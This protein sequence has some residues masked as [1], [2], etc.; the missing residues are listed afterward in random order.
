MC[1][2]RMRLIRCDADNLALQFR[3]SLKS[4]K[5]DSKQH[6]FV[7]SHKDATAILPPKKVRGR[8]E[9]LLCT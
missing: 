7:L 8:L 1:P 9:R 2:N 3:R 6:S 5:T 4:D